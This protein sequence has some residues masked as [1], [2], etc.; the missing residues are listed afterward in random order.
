MGPT[1]GILRRNPPPLVKDYDA[2]IYAEDMMFS[3]WPYRALSGERAAF[4]LFIHCTALALRQ[5]R[6]AVAWRR[7]KL[8]QQRSQLWGLNVPFSSTSRR[9]R[10]SLLFL[11]DPLLQSACRSPSSHLD[12]S[13]GLCAFSYSSESAS[14][15]KYIESCNAH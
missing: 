14:Y 7:P 13:L 5:G 8:M 12:E 11:L 4:V 3:C 10:I 9:A 1:T 15:I 2:D 6:Q